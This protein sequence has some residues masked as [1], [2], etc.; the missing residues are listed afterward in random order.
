M[1]TSPYPERVTPSS[2]VSFCYEKQMYTDRSGQGVDTRLVFY[3]EIYNDQGQDTGY[4]VDGYA[5]VPNI[6]ANEKSC[7]IRERVSAKDV[8]VS[9][10]YTCSVSWASSD[11]HSVD[12]QPHFSV[13]TKPVTVI[14][15]KTD[16][17]PTRARDL[18]LQYCDTTDTPR[19][20]WQKTGSS[21][22]LQPKGDRTQVTSVHSTCPPESKESELSYEKRVHIEWSDNI[23]VKVSGETKVS[24][25]GQE[26]KAS[27]ETE[28]S[29]EVT[30][31]TETSE[32]IKHFIPEGY[33]GALY[34]TAGVV[35]VKGTVNIFTPDRAYKIVNV[36]VD[37]PL[38]N[39]YR[40]PNNQPPVPVG[41]VDPEYWKCEEAQPSYPP[42]GSP[43]L[44]ITQS[45]LS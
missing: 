36:I 14:D 19:C 13:T 37:F 25:F 20:K 38:S 39:E 7:T 22:F 34:F 11:P 42:S 29:H 41:V 30:A 21:A 1:P 40:P 16:P 12:P 15:A 28:Y 33:R 5:F 9:A 24:I 6:G 2:S 31:G 44:Q 45:P 3:Y 10:P 4:Y 43:G 35:E 27:V 32:K 8:G 23:G 17:S 26:V 18:V